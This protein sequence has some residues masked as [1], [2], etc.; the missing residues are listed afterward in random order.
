LGVVKDFPTLDVVPP[1][2]PKYK[3]G[4]VLPEFVGAPKVKENEV[5]EAAKVNFCMAEA[6]VTVHVLPLPLLVLA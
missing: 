3:R 4:F 1:G 2:K 6:Y 5:W